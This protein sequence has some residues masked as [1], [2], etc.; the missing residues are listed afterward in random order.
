LNQGIGGGKK[1][2]GVF[3]K[4]IVGGK[5]GGVRIYDLV[6]KEIALPL[7]LSRRK[8]KKASPKE[9]RGTGS[10]SVGIVE[11]KSLRRCNFHVAGEKKK[12]V[13]KRKKK[14]GCTV[15]PVTNEG[16]IV[17]LRCI[18]L[19]QRKSSVEIKR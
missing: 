10:L 12:S 15:H 16:K 13:R 9:G 2:L 1:K 5:R 8:K 19:L 7:L 6:K 17:R 18:S 4:K 3:L 11:G 14:E